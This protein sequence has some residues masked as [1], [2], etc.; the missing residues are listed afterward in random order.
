MGFAGLAVDGS[1]IYYQTQRMQISA[2]AAALGGAR[3]LAASA[4]HNAVDAEIHQ[5]AFANHADTVS[6]SYIN[7]QSR[8]A[9]GGLAHF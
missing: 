5:L 3:K 6:W 4:E 7:N 9:C 2:D 8:G 1:N